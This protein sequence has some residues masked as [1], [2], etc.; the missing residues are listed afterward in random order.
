MC[1]VVLLTSD[2]VDS[3]MYKI[4]VLMAAVNNVLMFIQIW[5][6][7]GIGGVFVGNLLKHI[8]GKD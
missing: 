3:S 5:G 7:T 2:T 6:P 1:F 4:G 8:E